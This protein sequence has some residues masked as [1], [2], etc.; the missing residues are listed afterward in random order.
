MGVEREYTL[1]GPDK[2]DFAAKEKNAGVL[3]RGAGAARQ[4][5]EGRSVADVPGGEIHLEVIGIS[6][7]GSFIDGGWCL[8]AK[9][10][11]AK[12]EGFSAAA[13]G[14]SRGETAF[15]RRRSCKDNRKKYVCY[16]CDQTWR[17]L[18]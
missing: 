5:D 12:P 17:G 4:R 8:P 14:A 10:D 16:F 9:A 15:L 7:M 6:Y 3:S 13:G 11:T 2:I 1:I 18:T